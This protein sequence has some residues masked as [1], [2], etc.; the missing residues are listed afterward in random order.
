MEVAYTM[1]AEDVLAKLVALTITGNEDVAIANVVKAWESTYKAGIQDTEYTATLDVSELKLPEGYVLADTVEDITVTITSTTVK[2]TSVKA[3]AEAIDV[4]LNTTEED[5]LT[6]LGELTFVGNDDVEITAENVVWTV[7][8]YNAAEAGAYTASFTADVTVPN[9]YALAEGYTKVTVTVNVVKVESIAVTTAPTKTSYIEGDV[10]DATG[11]VVTATYSND[12]TKDV[13]ED[14]LKPAVALS[15]ETTEVVIEYHE[16]GVTVSTTVAVEVISYEESLEKVITAH[17]SFDDTLANDKSEGGSASMA[18]WHFGGASETAPTYA[19]GVKGK[20][21]YVTGDGTHDGIELDAKITSKDY[22]ISMWLKPET[23][24]AEFAGALYAWNSGSHYLTW[25]TQFDNGFVGMEYGGRKDT[26]QVANMFKTDRWSMVTYTVEGNVGK[27]YLDGELATTKEQAEGFFTAV[28]DV[29]IYLG[30]GGAWDQ[31]YRGSYDEVSMFSEALSEGQIKALYESIERGVQK[32]E[33]SES[34]LIVSSLV[35]EDQIK[36]KL[37]A[38]TIS[39]TMNTDALELPVITNDTNWT[40]T[41]V[42]TGYRATKEII[43][44]DGYNYIT[45]AVQTLTVD[46]VVSDADPETISIK[47]EPTKNRYYEGEVF[48]PTGLVITITY[49]DGVTKD[50]TEGFT[51]EEIDSLSLE[52]ASA[53]I[54]YTEKIGAEQKEVTITGELPINV[55]AHEVV[56]YSFDDTLASDSDGVSA[57]TLAAGLGDGSAHITTYAEDAIK[58]KS[59]NM[60]PEYGYLLG[61]IPEGCGS[62]SVSFWVKSSTDE[63]WGPVVAITPNKYNTGGENWVGLGAGSNGALKGNGSLGRPGGNDGITNTPKPL[64]GEWE[65]VTMVID[66][67]KTGNV[68][69]SVPMT[70]YLNGEVWV[71]AD[72]QNDVVKDSTEVYLGTNIW[73]NLGITGMVDELSFANYAYTAEEAKVLY[74]SFEKVSKIKDVTAEKS[75]ITLTAGATEDTVKEALAGIVLTG[76]NALGD[77]IAVSSTADAWTIDSYD[78]NEMGDYTA[79]LDISK[80]IAEGYTFAEGLANLQVTVTLTGELESIEITTAPT[81]TT[82]IEGDVFDTTGMVVTA[83]YTG[84]KTEDVASEVEVSKDA[85]TAGTTNITISYTKGDITKEVVQAITVLTVQEAATASY[86]FDES[87]VNG[88]VDNGTAVMINSISEKIS[89]E[90]RDKIVESS[91]A[92]TYIDGVNGKAIQLAGGVAGTNSD[93]IKLDAT[94]NS[95]TYT[96]SMWVKPDD[97]SSA[98]APIFNAGKHEH[99]HVWYSNNEGTDKIKIRSTNTWSVVKDTAIMPNVL[100]I[101]T[102][103]MLT[104]TMNDGYATFYLNGEKILEESHMK[105]FETFIKNHSTVPTLFLG[106]CSYDYTFAGAYDDVYIYDG[107]TLSAEQVKKLYNTVSVTE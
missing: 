77:T 69:N 58:G 61:N 74:K 1:S 11:M 23:Q 54:T 64:S 10:F 18:K 66:G 88:S 106:T 28:E 55:Y 96:V 36:E 63:F 104:L 75:A 47:T 92:P 100:T 53:T 50:L 99:L 24:K 38:L 3:S 32:V 7:E 45:G 6:K 22:T 73:A 57:T 15:L 68:A 48:D 87:L 52:N 60:I 72:I 101:D 19:D 25:Y 9:G 33:V 26:D 67:S 103:S 31:S 94:I 17:Y 44:P 62:A 86:G 56:T 14:I 105:F 78:A 70:I 79:T 20:A 107:I 81:K 80:I 71:T 12:K 27:V 13:T 49:T 93:G 43:L 30:T 39:A 84:G 89:A 95:D 85:L 59:V 46:V 97:L 51:V 40:L 102:W 91:T 4:D 5:V 42:D 37:A 16:N 2:I 35:T 41:K 8:N 98:Y 82:Y 65:Y 83:T 29:V 90:N 21:V 34:K 76:K